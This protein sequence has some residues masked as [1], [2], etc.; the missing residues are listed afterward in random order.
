MIPLLK[1]AWG[2]NTTIMF[3]FLFY[4]METNFQLTP[5]NGKWVFVAPKPKE[6]FL[7]LCNNF[8]SSHS[9]KMSVLS[10]SMVD[11]LNRQFWDHYVTEIPVGQWYT[12]ANAWPTGRCNP[13]LGPY[14][15]KIGPSFAHLLTTKQ[16][17]LEI[18]MLYR[19]CQIYNPIYVVLIFVFGMFG[20]PSLSIKRTMPRHST[21]I[22]CDSIRTDPNVFHEISV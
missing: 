14:S 4:F 2:Y 15:K 1:A 10:D 18:L 11:S 21:S 5:A 7:F 3:I 6:S 13:L 16:E 17:Q 22:R 9:W 12:L 20:H 19:H 8:T